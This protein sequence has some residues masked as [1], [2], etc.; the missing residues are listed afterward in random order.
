LFGGFFPLLW[1]FCFWLSGGE[2]FL[3]WEAF[4]KENKLLKGK[5]CLREKKENG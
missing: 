2:C 5:D 3:V 1:A 4:G